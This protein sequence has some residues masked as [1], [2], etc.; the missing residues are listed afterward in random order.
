MRE[1][2]LGKR[3]LQYSLVIGRTLWK[4]DMVVMTID[5]RK[6]LNAGDLVVTKWKM[7]NAEN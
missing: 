4:K 7:A 5:K 6:D 2:I 3:L 1:E